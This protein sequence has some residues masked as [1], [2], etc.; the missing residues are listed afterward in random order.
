MPALLDAAGSPGVFCKEIF[1]P[2]IHDGISH[3]N[4]AK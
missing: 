1:R 4:H 2:L 3:F